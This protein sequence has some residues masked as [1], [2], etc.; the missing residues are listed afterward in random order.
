MQTVQRLKKLATWRSKIRGRHA[1][2]AE[3]A[4]PWCPL[5][6]HSRHHNDAK[7]LAVTC[8]LPCLDLMLRLMNTPCR[9]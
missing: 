1:V 6:L 4:S 7:Q 9:D 5:R 8:T 3:K 2:M